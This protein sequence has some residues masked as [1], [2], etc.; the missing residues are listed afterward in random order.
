MKNLFYVLV[1]LIHI[2]ARCQFNLSDYNV[3]VTKINEDITVDGVLNEPVWLTMEEITDFWQH[4]PVD[5]VQAVMQTIVKVAYDDENIY[6]GALCK[7]KENTRPVIQN[8]IRDDNGNFWNSDGFSV[9]IDPLNTNKVGYYFALNVAGARQDAFVSQQG[10][11]PNL[12]MFWDNYW[13]GDASYSEGGYY[14]ELAIPFSSIKFNQ[15]TTTWGFNFIR[16]DMKRNVFD[17]WTKFPSTYDGLDFTF[18]G[19][20]TFEDG[21]PPISN[22]R[23]ELKPSVSGK[24]DRNAGEN[25]P[26]RYSVNAGIDAKYAVNENV[27]LDIALFPDFSTVEVDQQYIDFYRF[28]YKDPEQRDFFLENNDLFSSPGSDEDWSI[29][30]ADAYR[31]KPFYTR[32]I[33]IK[34][35]EHTP[36]VYG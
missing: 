17:L 33:G 9:I 23:F 25:K 1:F 7:E 12:D 8:L 36:I 15:E 31:I 13:S 30:P 19:Q 28:E 14:Y 2:S 21:L 34:D 16:N 11:Q 3:S 24:A 29:V 35:L 5:T 26:A 32:R 20:V 6:I 10:F 22:R 18:N 27:N 4:Y